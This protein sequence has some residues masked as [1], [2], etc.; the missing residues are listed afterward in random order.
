VIELFTLLDLIGNEIP[1]DGDENTA[2]RD[3]DHP[4]TP[5]GQAPRAAARR[6]DERTSLVQQHVH[7]VIR[8][9]HVAKPK[10]PFELGPVTTEIVRSR[11]C[12]ATSV[13]GRRHEPVMARA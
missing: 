4:A 9:N 6:G 2:R 12:A 1:D 13:P 10:T 5:A 8:L 11:H 3:A 7:A